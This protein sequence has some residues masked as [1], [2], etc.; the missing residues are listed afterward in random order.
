MSVV[1][2][3]VQARS[4][5]FGWGGEPVVADFSLSVAPGRVCVLLGPSGCGKTTVLRLLAGLLRPEAGAV[6]VRGPIGMAFQDPRLLPWMTVRENIGFALEAAGVPRAD[7]SGR[8]EPL[9]A[10]VGLGH[11]G[12]QRPDSLSGGMAQRASLA[13]AL[14]LAPACLLMDEPFGALDP[15][16]RERLQGDLQGALGETAAV[17][18]THDMA[19]A[20]VLG[21]EVLV[22]GAGCTIRA[23]VSVGAPRPRGEAWRLSEAFLALARE[24]RGALAQ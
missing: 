22:L 23:R 9:L 8:I 20:L 18:V 6:T 5:R 11:A 14:A 12:D 24:L 2:P 13:R 7:W 16:L 19:E 4:L 15:M 3:V 17:L 21:D 10:R 1:D